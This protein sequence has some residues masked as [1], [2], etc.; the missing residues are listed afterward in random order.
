M[1]GEAV[2]DRANHEDMTR[3]E[4][5][6]KNIKSRTSDATSAIGLTGTLSLRS[7]GAFRSPG[8]TDRSTISAQDLHLTCAEPS[9]GGLMNANALIGNWKLISWE[10]V[11]DGQARDVF[12]SRP[13]GQSA[14]G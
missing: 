12:G 7:L 3:L 4:P 2:A 14:R 10:V 8:S 6:A 9:R 13:R 1:R 5:L 11:V